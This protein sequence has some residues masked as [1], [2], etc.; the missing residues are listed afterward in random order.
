MC[1]L[2]HH[3]NAEFLL[4]TWL[5][6]LNTSLNDLFEEKSSYVFLQVL[7][8][9]R[10]IRSLVL[11]WSILCLCL[12]FLRI[13]LSLLLLSL[14]LLLLLLSLVID[15]AFSNRSRQLRF[16]KNLFGCSLLLFICFFIL[17]ILHYNSIN[18]N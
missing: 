13:L 2:I 11:L 8:N 12:R 6:F 17:N 4:I 18:Y 15:L 1:I 14:L 7:L 5:T 16:S 10:L 9:S 3:K